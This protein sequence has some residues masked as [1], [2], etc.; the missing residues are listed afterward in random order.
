MAQCSLSKHEWHDVDKSTARFFM[1]RI[2]RMIR[3][4]QVDDTISYARIARCR[5]VDATIFSCT[6]GTNSTMSINRQHDFF[7]HERHEWHDVDK[8]TAR[9]LCTK[10]TK[11]HRVFRLRKSC[12]SCL[13]CKEIVTR[14]RALRL[15]K[16]CHSCNSCKEAS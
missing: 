2:A 6:N 13:S 16:S 5:Q 15:R 3:C 8:S 4:R 14:N 11:K 1:A 10:D 7:M 9:F 12:H